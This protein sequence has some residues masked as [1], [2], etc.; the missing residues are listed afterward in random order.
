MTTKQFNQALSLATSKEN[1]RDASIGVFDGFGLPDF[2]VVYVT[3]RQV[4]RL[5]R[6]QALQ[7]NGELDQAAL[8][9]VKF[10]SKKRFSIIL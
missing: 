1:L 7:F 6:W 8:R 5:I 2:Q 3:L 4:A 9:E 10:F